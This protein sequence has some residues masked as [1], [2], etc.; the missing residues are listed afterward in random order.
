MDSILSILG[1]IASIGGAVWAYRQARRSKKYAT[2]ARRFRDD[3]INRRE[4]VEVSQ[5]YTETKR[6]LHVVSRVGPTCTA[7]SIKGIDCAG[8]AREVEE[9]S[10]FLN[11][12][13]SHFNEFFNN[14][15]KKLCDSLVGDI[16][17]LSEA[18]EFE[19]IKKNGKNI[20]YKIYEF[21]PFVKSLTDEKKEQ[22]SPFQEKR[23]TL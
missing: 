10:R 16:E 22:K 13:N 23:S 14:R 12:Q 6:I 8:I 19:D 7:D 4:L 18:L 3:I 1:S 9:Y 21:L 17:T 15:A 5:V 11:E 2:E 20:Y